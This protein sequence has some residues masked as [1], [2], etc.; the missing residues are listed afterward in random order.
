MTDS[1]CAEEAIFSNAPFSS[2]QDECGRF[3]ALGWMWQRE[4]QSADAPQV[5]Q[6]AGG[7]VRK[8]VKERPR[9]MK[10]VIF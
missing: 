8:R 2:L 7:M 9:N 4:D 10:T 6:D 5:S 1:H 3:R